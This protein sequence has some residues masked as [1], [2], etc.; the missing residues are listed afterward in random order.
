MQV[1]CKIQHFKKGS[2]SILGCHM[3]LMCGRMVECNLGLP[4]QYSY[5]LLCLNSLFSESSLSKTK[6]Y[7]QFLEFRAALSV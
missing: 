4:L 7:Q 5:I 1:I 6:D 2:G 3:L